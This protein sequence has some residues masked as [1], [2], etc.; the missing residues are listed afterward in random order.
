MPACP[1]SGDIDFINEGVSFD[2][3]D[4]DL[5]HGDLIEVRRTLIV[6]N[7]VYINILSEL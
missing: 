4:F 3:T 6:E 7:C 5:G 2:D 1:S